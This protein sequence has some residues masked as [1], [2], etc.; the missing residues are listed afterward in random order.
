MK[1]LEERERVCGWKVMIF[2]CPI[3][4]CP[5]YWVYGVNLEHRNTL[6]MG[7]VCR[8]SAVIGGSG[9]IH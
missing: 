4:V 3:F 1:C 5:M 9:S 8:R 6:S 7:R 2:M